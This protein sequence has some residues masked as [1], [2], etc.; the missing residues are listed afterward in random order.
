MAKQPIVAPEEPNS[1]GVVKGADGMKFFVSIA[2]G[3]VDVGIMDQDDGY[4]SLLEAAHESD[5]LVALMVHDDEEKL[6]Y[7]GLNKGSA[8]RPNQ[9]L[10]FGWPEIDPYPAAVKPLD[11]ALGLDNIAG[12]NY[13]DIYEAYTNAYSTSLV[14][15]FTS[16]AKKALIEDGQFKASAFEGL[17]MHLTAGTNVDTTLFN[18]DEN[19][20][21]AACFDGKI[22]EAMKIVERVIANTDGNGDYWVE[23]A[24]VTKSQDNKAIHAAYTLTGEGGPSDYEMT[25]TRCAAE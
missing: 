21:K 25:F 7:F 3:L 6:M 22:S 18:D 17:K 12:W 5:F 2:R 4:F 8:V 23:G 15:S 1:I 20:P 24:K 19:A 14:L 11:W 16:E 10:T 13:D 9:L